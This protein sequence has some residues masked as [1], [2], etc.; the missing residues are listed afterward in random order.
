RMAASAV[1][2]SSVRRSSSMSEVGGSGRRLAGAAIVV[3]ILGSGLAMTAA[4][5]QVS[6]DPKSA[7]PVARG[8]YLINAAGC[9]G[10]HTDAK[11]GGADLAGGRAFATP[12]GTFY[13]PNISADPSYGIGRWSAADFAQALHEGLRPDGQY[14][15]PVF[16]FTSFTGMS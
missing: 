3:L 5:A 14:L 4:R 2:P 13:S 9:I 10:C 12:F 1:I 15:Y 7:D 16:P 6:G 8:Q 11:S